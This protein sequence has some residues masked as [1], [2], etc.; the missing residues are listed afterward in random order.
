M[1]RHLLCLALA[2]ALAPAFGQTSVR[3]E[4]LR[5]QGHFK[6]HP[7]E[8]FYGLGI[9]HQASPRT[10]FGVTLNAAWS[11][12]FSKDMFQA[13]EVRW[14]Q[15]DVRYT[16]S[17]AAV[18]L[19]FRSDFAFSDIE[20]FHAFLGTTVA[21]S[22]IRSAVNTESATDAN[23]GFQS[24]TELGLRDRYAKSALIFP[25]GIRGGIRGGLGG[26]YAELYVGYGVNL[27]PEAVAVGA[28]FLGKGVPV[29]PTF[30]QFGLALGFGG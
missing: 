27:G 11:S 29:A 6:D 16:S 7:Q 26:T 21:M 30:L 2:C 12:L 5:F 19:D 14:R 9:D 10:S 4:L 1:K 20:E 15:Y 25:V 13:E 17:R 24:T 23:Y 28:P 18:N 3:T 8:L 22:W